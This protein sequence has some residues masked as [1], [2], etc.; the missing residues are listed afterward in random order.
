MK[1]SNFSARSRIMIF[2]IICPPVG[3]IPDIIRDGET[4]IFTKVDDENDLAEKIELLLND[5]I[6]SEKIVENGRKMVEEKFSW[7][8]IAFSYGN[9]FDKYVKHRA[10]NVLMATPLMPPQLGGPALYAKNLGEEFKKTGH[11]VRIL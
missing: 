1:M 5:R 3:G 2:R 9:L 10:F 7:G 8:K 11:N 4:G 6:L